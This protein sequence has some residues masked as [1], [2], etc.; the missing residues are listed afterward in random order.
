V[1]EKG[2]RVAELLGQHR[3]QIDEK[4][5]IALPSKYR[6]AF[7]DAVYLTLGQDGALYAYPEA[8][9]RAVAEGVR[10][11]PVSGQDARDRA[12]M[13]YANAEQARLDK[14]GRMVIPQV[15]REQIHLEREA[16]VL[17][18]GDHLEIWSGPAW[19]RYREQRV[20]TYVT[21]GLQ[22]EGH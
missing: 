15:L 10:S 18:L 19:D 1:E 3:Y 21:G 7:G 9:W 6:D 2:R 8:E 20:G 11:T 22:P 14:Q 12:R 13:F 16:V 17:G 5:R 4:G